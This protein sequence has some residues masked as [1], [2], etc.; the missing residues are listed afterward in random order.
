MKTY[1]VINLLKVM[2]KQLEKECGY[3]EAKSFNRDEITNENES[4]FEDLKDKAFYMACDLVHIHY[5]L[6]NTID[7]L[8][9]IE[10]AENLIDVID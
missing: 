8:Q 9:R 6:V 2:V 7:A 4:S 5:E 10:K 1:V 3:N